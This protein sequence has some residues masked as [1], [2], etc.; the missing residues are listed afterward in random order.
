[1][2]R[3]VNDDNTSDGSVLNLP[4]PP[5]TVQLAANAHSDDYICS[6]WSNASFSVFWAEG[7]RIVVADRSTNR[8]HAIMIFE[9]ADQVFQTL[10][11][12][13]F[14]GSW[15]FHGEFPLEV[16]G[17]ELIALF[18]GLRANLEILASTRG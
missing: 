11:A 4:P 13:D 2:V 15:T 7:D 14:I 10:G 8:P 17:H 1:M 3:S 5:F 12:W 6:T 9:E 18:V 16:S